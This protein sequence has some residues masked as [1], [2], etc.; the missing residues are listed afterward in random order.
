MKFSLLLECPEAVDKFYTTASCMSNADFDIHSI[1]HQYV[2]YRVNGIGSIR[3]HCYK[4][5]FS[6]ADREDG[7]IL[8][9]A[10]SELFENID[11]LIGETDQTVSCV[12][13]SN[14][15]KELMVIMSCA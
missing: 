9:T 11:G 14:E 7:E 6:E 15:R 1:L 2:E 12:S 10:I 8:F 13:L 4:Y 3:E 5:G